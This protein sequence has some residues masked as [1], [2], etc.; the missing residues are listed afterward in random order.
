MNAIQ[1]PI[2]TGMEA[3]QMLRDS[4]LIQAIQ[5]GLP[6]VERPY[7]AITRGHEIQPGSGETRKRR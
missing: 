3:E 1:A 7:A 5:D 4:V 6:L 2:A